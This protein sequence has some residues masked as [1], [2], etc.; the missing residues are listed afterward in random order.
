[1]RHAWLLTGLLVACS[2]QTAMPPPGGIFALEVTDASGAM[3][4]GVN[5]ATTALGQDRGAVLIVTN[6]GSVDTGPIGIAISGPA[7]N[8][9]V[10]DNQL[11]NCATGVAPAA[12]CNV[13]IAFR[14]TVVGLRTATL[15]IAF[16]NDQIEIQLAGQALLSALQFMPAATDF[17]QVETTVVAHATVTIRNDGVGDSPIDAIAVTGD[18]FA[19]GTT[20]CA[21]ALGAG[22]ACDVVV[23]FQPSALGA[24]A[25]MLSLTSGAS[26]LSEP[27]AAHGARR[28]TV[29]RIGTGTGTVTSTPAGIDCGATCSALF[30]SDVT[31]AEAPDAGAVF[32]GWSTCGLETTCTVPGGLDPITVTADFQL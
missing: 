28:I 14:P 22:R 31:L 9:F 32:A 16:G 27:L 23:D 7:A 13:A 10:I 8:E 3:I 24:Q 26:T 2:N 29:Q 25:A 21:A 11:T 20:T 18:G 17:G 6:T 30:E 19:L 4:T 1:M 12:Q 15:A 5:F